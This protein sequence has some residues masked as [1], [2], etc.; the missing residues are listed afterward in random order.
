MSDSIAPPPVPSSPPPISPRAREV[1]PPSSRRTLTSEE[2]AQRLIADV[3]GSLA[4]LEQAATVRIEE[5]AAGAA[6]R[7][8]DEAGL[9]GLRGLNGVP[10]SLAPPTVSIRPDPETMRVLMSAAAS[11]PKQS[12]WVRLID[13]ALFVAALLLLE[14]LLHGH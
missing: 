13:K 9:A 7:A 14:L 8:R 2:A 11:G 1:T 12:D 4:R 6:M 3:Q 5:A 10:A